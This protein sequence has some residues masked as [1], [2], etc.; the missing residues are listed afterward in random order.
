M[1]HPTPDTAS[2][3]AIVGDGNVEPITAAQE[4]ALVLQAQ[5]G[6]EGAVIYLMRLYA[7][8]LRNAVRR[9]HGGMDQADV[10]QEVA[11]AFL[12]LVK[13]HDPSTGRL[14]GRVAA[15][16]ADGVAEAAS[17]ENFMLVPARSVKRFFRILKEADGDLALGARL[18]AEGGR[19][20]D[21]ATF[22]DIARV[23]SA[24]SI[25]GLTDRADADGST[26]A[27]SARSLTAPAVDG[28]L[29]VEDLIVVDAL[30][31]LLDER[32]TPIIRFSYGFDSLPL[33]AE[34]AKEGAARTREEGAAV[35]NDSVVAR[36][37][38][39]TR[40]T[41]QRVRSQALATMRAE[42]IGEEPCLLYTSPSPRD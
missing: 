35:A 26:G 27:H 4:A 12:A 2:I 22:L 3:T 7:P 6:N 34:E 23:L 37:L 17:R 29:A 16:L 24:D 25:E 40:G 28:Y 8:A 14:A 11:L 31:A 30:L 15:Y 10:E 32:E 21:P 41:V 38:G 13:A 42:V 39:M 20:M 9:V 5:D 33:S 36:H 18:A 1:I 19:E